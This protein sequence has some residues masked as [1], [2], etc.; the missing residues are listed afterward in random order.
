MSH[1]WSG[2]STDILIALLISRKIRSPAERQFEGYLL[3]DAVSHAHM[4]GTK[5]L[6]LGK[7]RRR[8]SDLLAIRSL[9]KCLISA[10]AKDIE[11]RTIDQH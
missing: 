10:L 7:I 5:V 1:P 8:G 6:H 2:C 4:Y 3:W 9:I 11:L